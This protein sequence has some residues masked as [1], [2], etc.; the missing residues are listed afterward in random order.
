MQL[1]WQNIFISKKKCFNMQQFNLNYDII[2]YP[3]QKGWLKI[4]S[5]LS[6]IYKFKTDKELDNYIEKRYSICGGYKD[7]MWSIM[8]DL[9]EL[10]FN[11]TDYL[12]NMTIKL[13]NE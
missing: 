6:E 12:K 9:H 11:G 10:F 3:S 2:I 7:H 5:I 13:I 8:S 1:K 4:R